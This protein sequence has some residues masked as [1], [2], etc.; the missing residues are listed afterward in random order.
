MVLKGRRAVCLWPV[1]PGDCAKGSN[2]M[3]EDTF[4][5]SFWAERCD[6]DEVFERLTQAA[7]RGDCEELE[8]IR[9]ER[10][11]TQE[12]IWEELPRDCMHPHDARGPLSCAV[13]SCKPGVVRYLFSTYHLR[14]DFSDQQM[15]AQLKYAMAHLG[16][17]DVDAFNECLE[18][19]GLTLVDMVHREPRYFVEYLCTARGA[20]QLKA[21]LSSVPPR[22]FPDL[23]TETLIQFLLSTAFRWQRLHGH[24]AHLYREW[25]F[26]DSDAENLCEVLDLT[27]SLHPRDDLT[28]PI[29]DVVAKL[30]AGL[31]VRHSQTV[32][33]TL[34]RAFDV[35]S[36]VESPRFREELLWAACMGEW[37]Q[38]VTVCRVL[39]VRFSGATKMHLLVY[40]AHNADR[41]HALDALLLLD[42]QG[43][44]TCA[45]AYS[46]LASEHM[47]ATYGTAHSQRHYGIRAPI[48]LLFETVSKQLREARFSTRKNFRESLQRRTDAVVEPGLA[49][50]VAAFGAMYPLADVI[51]IEWCRQAPYAYFQEEWGSWE[52]DGRWNQNIKEICGARPSQQRIMEFGI[53]IIP[54]F[55][56]EKEAAR[57]TL[58]LLLQGKCTTKRALR[59]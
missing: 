58:K 18:A 15:R 28:A 51:D 53:R 32:Y 41:P 3:D 54:L 43:G 4:L 39:D 16:E 8:R 27:L 6:L 24:P 49:A 21:S 56:D 52:E 31:L 10:G 48:Q 26:S 30:V 12:L 17:T 35:A 37:Q 7:A 13:K 45:D 34:S 14:V 5:G 2:G 9:V 19:L 57:A 40:L 22:L 20:R 50:F 1:T 47:A 29:C 23:T 11:V 44:L 33:T 55:D 59:D 46:T 25:M 38:V 36:F 42:E